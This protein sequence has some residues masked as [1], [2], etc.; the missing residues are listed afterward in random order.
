MLS[1]V[2]V[3]NY[4]RKCCMQSR[5]GIPKF[6]YLLVLVCNSARLKEPTKL[7]EADWRMLD[8]FLIEPTMI[9]WGQDSFDLLISI[10]RFM[11]HE[12]FNFN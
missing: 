5:E 6:A 9:G 8:R 10:H 1:D 3:R 2:D 4:Q 7:W 12:I 11:M